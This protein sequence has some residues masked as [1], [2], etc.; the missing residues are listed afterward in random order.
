MGCVFPLLC[1]EMV[2]QECLVRGLT[3]YF[4]VVSASLHRDQLDGLAPP[5]MALS[6]A[7]AGKS[8]QVWKLGVL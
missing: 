6:L 3:H 1:V 2:L 8:H 7:P 4:Q 5:S